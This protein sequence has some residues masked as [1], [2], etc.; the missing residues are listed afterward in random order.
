MNKKLSKITQA[1]ALVGAVNTS[2][3]YYRQMKEFLDEKI[4]YTAT[5][6]QDSYVYPYLMVWLNEQTSPRK[7]TFRSKVN[8]VVRHFNASGET[9]VN[10]DGHRIEVGLSTPKMDTAEW[11]DGSVSVKNEI[12]FHSRTAAGM[13][14]VENLLNYLTE[15]RRMNETNIHLFTIGKYGWDTKVMPQRDINSVF[16][17]TGVKEDLMEDIENFFRN[18]EQFKKIGAP[19][20]RGYLFHG[21]PGNGK[22]SMCAAIA[23]HYKMHVYSMPLSSVKDDQTLAES[24]SS[25]AP[26]SMLLLEDI[27]I[28]SSATGREQKDGPTLA[29]LLNAL[30]GVATPHGLMTFMTTNHIHS[31]DP[32]LIRNGRIDKRVELLAPDNTQIREMFEYAF[33]EPLNVEPREF[34]SMAALAEVFKR[35]CTDAEA[36]RMEIKRP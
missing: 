30:D 13:D 26:R 9:K 19:W 1:F 16:L 32:A 11:L 7:I 18:E 6:E 17:P 21:P 23:N 4:L 34:S 27:D 5:V 29:G 12:V 28:F 2:Y 14:A 8:G 31:L 20:H 15:Q 24:I 35:H 36:V 22:S 33:D 25:I 10:I 3:G